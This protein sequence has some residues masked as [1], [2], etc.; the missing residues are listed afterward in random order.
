MIP[1]LFFGCLKLG[2]QINK[3]N[4][5][6]ILNFAFDNG[7]TGYD[8]SLSYGYGR[9]IELLGEFSKNKRDKIFISSK[10]GI[11]PPKY[12]TIYLLAYRIKKKLSINKIPKTVL[13]NI[14]NS[15]N[16]EV[17]DKKIIEEQLNIS[18]KKLNTDYIDLLSLHHVNISEVNDDN[19]FFLKKLIKD[20][21]IKN[22]GFSPINDFDNYLN[23]N[24]T[25]FSYDYILNNIEK[26]SKIK[27]ILYILFMVKKIK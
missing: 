17:F 23:Y 18:L 3:K 12:K 4:D 2:L 25:H 27:I 22:Y 16:R 24:F 10:I 21:K 8:T 11:L 5:T 19:I 1:N 20:G 6:N 14:K 26:I 13:S 9:S 15:F 7:I